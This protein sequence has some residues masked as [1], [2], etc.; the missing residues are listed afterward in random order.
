MMRF[1]MK[2]IGVAAFVLWLAPG[3]AVPGQAI[4]A[5]PTSPAPPAPQDGEKPWFE[6]TKVSALFF[7]DAYLVADHHDGAIEGQNGFWFRRAYLT[8]DFA[9][10]EAWSTR[11]RFESNS[12]GDFTTSARLDPFVKDAYLAW[13]ASG[14]EL[15]IGI[16]PSPALESVETFWGYRAVEKTPLDL[17]RLTASREFGLATKGRAAGGK[18]FY[19]AAIGNGAGENSETNEGKKVSLALGLQP[20]HRWVFEIYA[21]RDDRP[22]STDRTTYQAFAGWRGAKGRFGVQYASQDRQAATGPDATL[23]LGSAIA[24]WDLSERWSLLAR[25]DR[26]FDPNP[27]ADRI[28]YL[29]PAK[30]TEFDLIVLGLDYRLHKKISL[31]PNL[32]W[33]RYRGTDGSAAPGDDLIGRLTLYFQF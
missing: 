1:A 19:H 24:V 9:I 7:G 30:N 15:Y 5:P 20:D 6:R 22:G 3:G 13:K 12:P 17:Y 8:F 23:A 10:S 25:L 31:I 33:V 28:L 18:L 11:L 16:S 2:R 21:D 4:E 29:V 26:S 14:R 32:Q 27:E